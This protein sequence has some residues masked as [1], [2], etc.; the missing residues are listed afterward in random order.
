MTN[1]LECNIFLGIYVHFLLFGIFE[2]NE[3]LGLEKPP[4]TYP[5]YI[6]FQTQFTRSSQHPPPLKKKFL[7][8]ELRRATYLL[9]TLILAA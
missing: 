2:K 6:F 7:S 5:A 9:L 8:H 1:D 3:I 4:F